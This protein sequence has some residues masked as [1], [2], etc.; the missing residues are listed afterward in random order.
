MSPS[1]TLYYLRWVFQVLVIKDGK[2]QYTQNFWPYQ[3][4]IGDIRGGFVFTKADLDLMQRTREVLESNRF[5]AWV[6]SVE[7]EML[8]T[9]KDSTHAL[10]YDDKTLHMSQETN[11]KLVKS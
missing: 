8:A 6:S 4:Q 9:L 7:D 1:S 10:A 11:H 3:P 5:G 2:I